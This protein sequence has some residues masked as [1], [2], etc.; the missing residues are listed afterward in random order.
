MLTVSV[1][2]VGDVLLIYYVFP[3]RVEDHTRLPRALTAARAL[4]A[5]RALTDKPSMTLATVSIPSCVLTS[6]VG[7]RHR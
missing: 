3:G 6:V 1:E 7:C 2:E 4:M 5:D